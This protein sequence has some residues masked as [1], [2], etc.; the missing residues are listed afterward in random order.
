[1]S[2]V[3]CVEFECA[4]CPN[5]TD[6]E[7][8]TGCTDC[9]GC[10]DCTGGEYNYSCTN[11]HDCV[12]CEDCTD[13]VNCEGC[14]DVTGG[15][16]LVDCYG[17]E[18]ARKILTK[19]VRLA[20]DFTPERWG[21]REK[22]ASLIQGVDFGCRFTS[23]GC[24][25]SYYKGTRVCCNECANRCGY[26]HYLPG[27]ALDPLLELWDQKNGFW[28]PGGCAVPHKWR[29]PVCLGHTCSS[30]ISQYNHKKVCQIMNDYSGDDCND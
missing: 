8:C 1:M 6:C 7:R 15:V 24:N 17:L 4:E 23:E 20:G 11:C 5:N 13:C 3:E 30:V 18:Y 12:G 10:V 14:K 22:R 27:E 29:S 26:M 2:C 28:T 19:A 25:S 16:D 9:E 21:E